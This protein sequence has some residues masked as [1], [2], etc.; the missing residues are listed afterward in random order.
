MDTSVEPR[1]GRAGLPVGARAEV[2]ERC[3]LGRLD[4]PAL[5][6]E[7]SGGDRLR[8]P[9]GPMTATAPPTTPTT[10]GQTNRPFAAPTQNSGAELRLQ[11]FMILESCHSTW[12]FDPVRMQFCRILKGIEVAGRSVSTAWR[13]YWQLELDPEMEAFSV[14]LNAHRT[15]LIRSWRHTPNCGQCS[16][17][18]TSEL[19]SSDL[20]RI[21]QVCRATGP[22]RTR[23]PTPTQR[24]REPP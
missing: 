15:R 10:Q 17:R 2:H 4:D 1:I 14:Y 16:G 13:P 12:V 11:D 24:T 5:R 19:S 20:P 21:V 3:E 8:T 6:E 22:Q 7:S 23:A 9:G 18:E